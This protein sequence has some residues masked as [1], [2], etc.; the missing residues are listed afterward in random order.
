MAHSPLTTESH[1]KTV[2]TTLTAACHRRHLMADSKG[3]LCTRG[4]MDYKTGCCKGGT[5]HSCKG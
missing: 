2:G 3:L 4:E 5:L 1:G